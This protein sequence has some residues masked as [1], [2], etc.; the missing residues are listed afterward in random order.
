MPTVSHHPAVQTVACTKERKN[1]S[2][3]KISVW[4]KVTCIISFVLDDMSQC[5]QNTDLR[6]LYAILGVGNTNLKWILLLW[7]TLLVLSC[8]SVLGMCQ[9]QALVFR[10]LTIMSLRFATALGTLCSN[11]VPLGQKISIMSV[12]ALWRFSVLG[13]DL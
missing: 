1:S 8:C 9:R 2:C 7:A 11:R 4:I 6:L 13:K 12:R 3:P 5:F 10:A